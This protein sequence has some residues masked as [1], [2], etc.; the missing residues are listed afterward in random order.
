MTKIPGKGP[1]P[2]PL[3]DDHSSI[4]DR[5]NHI[6]SNLGWIYYKSFDSDI[7]LNVINRAESDDINGAEL[8]LVDYYNDTIIKSKLLEL[9]S[10]EAFRQR[11]PLAQ[12]AL[13]DHKKERYHSS[14]PVVLALLDGMV[15]EAY[16]NA[17]GYKLNI[18]AEDTNYNAWISVKDHSEAL[19]AL[20]GILRKGRYSTVTEKI[21]KPYRNGILHGMDL[22]YDNKAVAAK[23]WAALFAIRDWAEEAENGLLDLQFDEKINNKNLKTN[24]ANGSLIKDIPSLK[25][26][27]QNIECFKSIKDAMPFLRPLLGQLGVDTNQIEKALPKMELLEAGSEML[28]IPD[29]FNDLFAER[30]WINYESISYE[31]AKAVIQKAESGDYDGAEAELVNYYNE[32][33][34]RSKIKRMKDVKAFRPR[35]TLAQ[36]ALTD[37]LEG[38]YHAC[39]PVVLAL[40]D[41]IVNEAHEKGRGSKL[42]FSAKKVNLEAWDSIS[43]HA[44][45]LKVMASLFNEDRGKTTVDKI[46][47]PYRNGILHGMDL[48]YDNKIVAAKAWAALFSVRAWA[49]KAEQGLLDPQPPEKPITWSQMIKQISDN[50]AEN[51]E[52]SRWKPRVIRIGQDIPATGGPEMYDAGTPERRLAEFLSI[53][54]NPKPNFR[55]MADC[56]VLDLNDNAKEMPKCIREIYNSKHLMHFDFTDIS[57]TAPATTIIQA[58][59]VYDEYDARVDKSV[60]FIMNN[61]NLEGGPEI[62]GKAGSNWYIRFWNTV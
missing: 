13:I 54:K 56:V 26:L 57:D 35:W 40:L 45:G 48:G 14:V 17:G 20:V 10:L 16:L 23:A 11:W 62:R 18:S 39:V 43:G 6:F 15:T 12:K 36:K 31:I 28:C 61:R 37:Y 59:L 30:G 34:I 52:L 38:R 58:T 42:G 27:Q 1:E 19:K 8:Y 50:D 3:A 53:W 44:K 46:T 41:G 21:D 2:S 24:K 25:N 9:K 51:L 7:A 33:T 47:T 22:G 60:Q 49:M 29:R 55:A 5:F 32:E 4:H